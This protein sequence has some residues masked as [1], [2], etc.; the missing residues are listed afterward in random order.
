MRLSKVR[1]ARQSENQ[2]DVS[3][4]DYEVEF[5]P[6][7]S[8]LQM[9]REIYSVED[10]SLSFRRYCCNRGVCGSCTM[11]INGKV[12]RACVTLMSD[13]MIIEPIEKDSVIK[14]LVTKH[15]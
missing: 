5:D 3:Y 7:K 4:S 9:L 6:H 15:E 1:I 14:D 10:R 12:K 11:I 8:V 2:N 13:E